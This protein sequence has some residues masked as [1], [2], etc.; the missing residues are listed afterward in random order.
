MS[1]KC[2][3][4]GSETVVERDCPECEGEGELDYNPPEF[5]GVCGG[6]GSIQGE[7]ECLDCSYEW[8]E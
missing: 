7:L 2:P 3:R 1:K 5:C 4:C 8:D 6:V